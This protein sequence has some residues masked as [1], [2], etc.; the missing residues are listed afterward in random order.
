[1]PN[2]NSPD[3]NSNTYKGRLYQHNNDINAHSDYHL[4]CNM[5]DKTSPNESHH[6]TPNGSKIK[7]HIIDNSTLPHHDTNGLNLPSQHIDSKP[8]SSQNTTELHID[9]PNL[10]SQRLYSQ[11]TVPD[12]IKPDG[13]DGLLDETEVIELSRGVR[14]I[15]QRWILDYASELE[16]YSLSRLYSKLN[17]VNRN[18]YITVIVDNY[19]KRFGLYSKDKWN[20]NNNNKTN[21]SFLWMINNGNINIYRNG[22]NE[23]YMISNKKFIAIGCNNSKFAIYIDEF[24]SKG[25]SQSIESYKNP[26]LS[27]LPDFIIKNIEIWGI[28]YI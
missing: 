9:G 12:L 23:D 13:Y 25:Y 2:N 6:T 5:N 4:N 15:D 28:E 10:T 26:I 11:T 17:N 1:M 7:P 21:N 27:T 3:K 20:I 16:G 24:I 19:N 14:A 18:G 8:L 22:I